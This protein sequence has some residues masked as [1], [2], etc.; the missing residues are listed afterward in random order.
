MTRLAIALAVVTAALGLRF[1]TFVA[2]GA[3]SYGYV[4]Q[5]DLWLRRTL[6]I[7]Q[8]LGGDA[9][10]LYANWTL[11][12]LGYRPGDRGGT[13]VP[14]YSPGLPLLMAG[15]KAAGG[16][17]AVYF[18]VPLL[19]ALAVWLTFRLGLRF[20]DR[21]AAALAAFALLVSPAFLFQL[22]WPMSDVPVMTWWLAAI[23]LAFGGSTVHVVLSGLAAAAAI[24][25][26]P[27]LFPL[28]L[29]VA[30]LIVVRQDLP[31]LRVARVLAF[32]VAVLPGPIAIALINDHLYGSPFS[33]GYG[34]FATIYAGRHLATNVV[35]YPLWLMQ[36]QT[37]FILLALAAPV[38]L[39]RHGNLGATRLATFALVFSFAVLLLYLWYTPYD[40]WTYLRFL[41]PA[42]PVMLAAS[43]A[44]FSL[45]APK[46]PRMRAAAFIVVALV[47]ATWGVWQ[48][49]SAFTVQAEEARYLAAGRFAAALPENAVIL[50]NQH[51]G[52][53]RYYANRI[54]LRF[55]WLMPD[56]YASALEYLRQSGRPVFVV[57]DEWERDV[58]RSRYAAVADV[59][60]LDAPPVLLAAK[61]VYFYQLWPP[62]R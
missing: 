18:A 60:W 58:F 10:W 39:R 35:Q 40:H 21:H 19:G 48:A 56:V 47:L 26:R 3:D 52:S 31:R 17:R 57:L 14:T 55:E 49:R 30:A 32:I 25:T 6:I 45:I 46:A 1:G 53:L 54:T 51:S 61:R 11:S 15:L 37:P 27:N 24:L 4:S 28:A 43:A 8:P 36:T 5:A 42:Y 12:P 29:L 41:L 59:S 50:C 44:A 13:M 62:P 38:L 20:G 7:D 2:S 23:V 33:S 16:E 22:M 34:T 9:P